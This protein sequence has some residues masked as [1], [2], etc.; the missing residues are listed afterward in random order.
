[1]TAKIPTPQGVSALLRE[2]GFTAAGRY[3][4][5]KGFRAAS[6]WT[7]PTSVSVQFHAA[8]DRTSRELLAQ[9]AL[10]LTAYGYAVETD[11]REPRLIVTPGT[12]EGTDD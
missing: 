5:R 6:P 9:A 4:D 1:M 8:D 10:V 11:M 2:A 3:R 12:G 7:D